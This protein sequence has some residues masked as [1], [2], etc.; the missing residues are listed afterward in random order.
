MVAPERLCVSSPATAIT[1]P[2]ARLA[3]AFN[4]LGR[5]IRHCDDRDQD[6]AFILEEMITLHQATSALLELTMNEESEGSY[7]ASAVCFRYVNDVVII[8]TY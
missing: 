1:S 3:Q 5:V 8:I 7:V 4:L 2:Y 6:L